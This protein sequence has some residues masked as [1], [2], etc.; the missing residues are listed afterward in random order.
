MEELLKQLNT[1]VTN[2]PTCSISAFALARAE[3]DKTL[4]LIQVEVQESHSLEFMGTTLISDCSGVTADT[5][6]EFIT[7]LRNLQIVSG[8]R[9]KLLKVTPQTIK[10]LKEHLK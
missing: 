5:G 8:K 4:H 1:Q 7:L 6:A 9:P 10:M 2:L 3:I